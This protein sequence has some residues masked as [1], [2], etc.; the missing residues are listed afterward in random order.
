MNRLN[1]DWS[2]WE[3]LCR[4]ASNGN[5]QP[6]KEV[7]TSEQFPYTNSLAN[8]IHNLVANFDQFA[9]FNSSS[10]FLPT[11]LSWHNCI[12]CQNLN[13]IPIIWVVSSLASNT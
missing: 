10:F 2:F 1:F 11:I 12:H 7:D 9:K 5:H 6:K 4:Q 8:T 3:E 13:I